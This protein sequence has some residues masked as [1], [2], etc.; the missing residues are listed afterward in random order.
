MYYGVY[1][2]CKRAVHADTAAVLKAADTKNKDE[3]ADMPSLEAVPQLVPT[4]SVVCAPFLVAAF[5]ATATKRTHT[6]PILCRS[7]DS[8]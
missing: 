7:V 6:K 1:I 3:H 2:W 5:H 4:Q 8:K